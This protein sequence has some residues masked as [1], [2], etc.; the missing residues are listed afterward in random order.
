VFEI[1]SYTQIVK[2]YEGQSQELDLDGD[3]KMDISLKLLDVFYNKVLVQV[4]SLLR[5]GTTPLKILPPAKQVRHELEI[6]EEQPSE[7]PPAEAP[8]EK[9]A[10]KAP[11]TQPAA[12][13]A[14]APKAEEGLDFG[15]VICGVL[16][17]AVVAVLIIIVVHRRKQ[18]RLRL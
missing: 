1:S 5:K 14:P 13:A 17:A 6:V 2:L 18:Q 15:W 7:Q 4:T 9:P 12:P 16:A 3:S 8:A 11:L 10:A